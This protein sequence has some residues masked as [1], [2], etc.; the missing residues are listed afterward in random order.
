MSYNGW[1]NYETW[2]VG[3]WMDNEEGSH[4]FFREQAREF[5]DD[6]TA[7]PG[8]PREE[9]ASGRFAEYLKEHYD[10]NIPEMPGVYGDLLGGALSEVNWREIAQ[11]YV[12][13]I[14]EEEVTDATS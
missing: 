6:C 8:I 3:L 7:K 14:I 4:A 13:Y 11:H 2:C 5:Y 1:T 12:D 10:E 9:V